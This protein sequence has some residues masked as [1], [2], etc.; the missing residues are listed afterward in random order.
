MFEYLV[1]H[2]FF[3]FIFFS[4]PLSGWYIHSRL[5]KKSIKY[6]LYFTIVLLL[7]ALAG[8]DYIIDTAYSILTYILLTCLYALLMINSDYKRSGTIL[9]SSLLFCI[10]G[11]VSFFSQIIGFIK[12]ENRW[13]VN[14]YRIEYVADQG[15]AG[16]ARMTY[17]LSRYA[18]IPL[19]IKHVDTQL[20][21]TANSCWVKFT[22]EGFN[23]NRCSIDS[24]V[25]VPNSH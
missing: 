12:V 19:F 7:P 23:F 18:W 10:C 2:S 24:S 11:F 8:Y 13:N 22:N 15:F 1:K 20:Q 6:I 3:V 9:I 14:G 25:N 4:I 21:D 16:G 5:S 17:E